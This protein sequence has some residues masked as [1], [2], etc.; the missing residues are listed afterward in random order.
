MC[1]CG[2]YAPGK[3]FLC[4][5]LASND[6]Y[7][8]R[9]STY[10]SPS[11]YMFFFIYPSFGCSDAVSSEFV[12]CQTFSVG[13]FPPCV[14]R[15]VWTCPPTAL[16]SRHRATASAGDSSCVLT[17]PLFLDFSGQHREF[18]CLSVCPEPW[19]LQWVKEG[20]RLAGWLASSS[21]ASTHCC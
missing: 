10:I 16:V 9:T 17:C 2:R 20:V 13:E 14:D 15:N 21:S 8:V 19:T 1:V 7:R 5:T 12:S 18:V 11:I 4:D 6:R 3:L